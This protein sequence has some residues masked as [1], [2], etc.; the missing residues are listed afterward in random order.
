MKNNFRIIEHRSLV[1]G[2]HDNQPETYLSRA[3][4]VLLRRSALLINS[5]STTAANI[6]N[7]DNIK[8]NHGAPADDTTLVP[9]RSMVLSFSQ[10]VLYSS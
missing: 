9:P 2:T 8:I 1:F 6:D 7:T 3:A 4:L 5:I 10:L